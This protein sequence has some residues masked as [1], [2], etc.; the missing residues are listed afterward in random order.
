M[1]DVATRAGVSV[2][3]VSRVVNGD[4]RVGADLAAGVQK[5]VTELGY[6]H[7]VTARNLRLTGQPTATVGLIVDDVA[8]PFF[9]AVQRA[10]EDTVAMHDS[11]VLSGSSDGRLDREQALVSAFTTRRVD[12]LIMI[13]SGDDQRY[14]QVELDR[15]LAL[16]L[17][18]RPSTSI[19]ADT[20]LSAN[21]DGAVRA[22]RHLI[23]H[24]H[25]RI[26]FLGHNVEK[27]RTSAERLRGYRTALVAAGLP[28]DPRLVVTDL[29][30]DE[31]A[32]R[33]ARDLLAA[34][35][36][37]T[38]LF[39]CHNRLTVGAR[40]ALY[41]LR[42]ADRVAQV[43]FDDLTFADLL[44]PGLTVVAQDPASIGAQAAELLIRRIGGVDDVPRTH[45]LP[46]TLI[47]RGSGEIPADRF[48]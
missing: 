7:N 29:P 10:V 20:V 23:D 4:P 5:A 37:P 6:Q 40:H 11:L 13:P 31:A 15:G 32:E 41:R 3:T 48:P 21:F 28:V 16:V 46:V 19:V 35:G 30:S 24:G 44:E 39:T 18:D 34:D 38:A 14:L 26:A 45:E 43:G 8:N 27:H 17:V 25:R 9:S 12:G 22:V 36:P 42:A 33:A 47:V 1:R 2:M